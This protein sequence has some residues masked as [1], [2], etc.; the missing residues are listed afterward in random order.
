[1]YVFCLSVCRF[2]SLY[3]MS[4][5]NSMSNSIHENLF[6]TSCAGCIRT[7]IT[8]MSTR[9]EGFSQI[10]L[11]VILGSEPYSRCKKLRDV[12]VKGLFYVT[13]PV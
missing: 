12:T 10:N 3:S 11:R 1:M 8:L 13:E 4:R 7:Y 5:S 2:L 9:S 6:V